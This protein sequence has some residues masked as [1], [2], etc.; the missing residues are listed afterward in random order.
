[1]HTVL[2]IY[3]AEVYDKYHNSAGVKPVLTI[4]FD[5]PE[6]LKYNLANGSAFDM[7]ECAR[8]KSCTR[9]PAMQLASIAKRMRGTHQNFAVGTSKGR[10]VGFGIL[11]REDVRAPIE[12]A[13]GKTLREVHP[14]QR[15][16]RSSN[17]SA[18]CPTMDRPSCREQ[19]SRAICHRTPQSCEAHFR[20]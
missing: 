12:V 13:S 19:R 14:R 20:L 1:M 3:K 11:Q 4:S 7:A 16:A 2:V 15:P 5:V 8:C 6:C 9:W 10:P 17:A 18:A